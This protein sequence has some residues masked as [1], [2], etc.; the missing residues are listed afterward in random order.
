MNCQKARLLI[1]E[2]LD[3]DRIDAAAGVQEHLKSCKE[4]SRYYDFWRSQKSLTAAKAPGGLAE[5]I[6]ERV[7]AEE[8]EPSR[9]AAH[10]FLKYVLPSA[11]VASL[12]MFVSVRIF[13]VRTTVPVTF[14]ISYDN[15]RTIA[16]AGDFNGWQNDKIF[17][18]K[19][20]DVWEATVRLKPS[21]YQYLFVIDGDKFVPDPDAQLCVD[22]GFGQKNSVVDVARV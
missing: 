19:N 15:A 18:K 11:L 2:L 3:K 20:G 17:L 21:R 4:C 7:L 6:M 8:M 10:P 1:E 14:R 13:T 12:L 16:L 22:D 5:R 9:S